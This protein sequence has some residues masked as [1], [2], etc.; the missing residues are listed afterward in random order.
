M[1]SDKTFLFECMGCKGQKMLGQFPPLC[2]PIMPCPHNRY[3]RVQVV[4]TDRL[5]SYSV[6]QRSSVTGEYYL[7]CVDTCSYLRPIAS[8]W[9]RGRTPHNSSWPTGR[10][11]RPPY[12]AGLSTRPH[13]ETEVDSALSQKVVRNHDGSQIFFLWLDFILSLVHSRSAGSQASVC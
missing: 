13:L 9:R 2:S 11:A 7:R 1:Q 10:H 4:N 6:W 5:G 8:C 12:R 3:A